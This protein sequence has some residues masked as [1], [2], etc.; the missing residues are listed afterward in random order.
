MMQHSIGKH[1]PI[2]ALQTIFPI[3]VEIPCQ[4]IKIHYLVLTFTIWFNW[5]A[6]L[7]IVAHK[8][9]FMEHF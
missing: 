8:L 9:G 2:I 4:W 1:F 7:P 6:H 5:H 3:Y